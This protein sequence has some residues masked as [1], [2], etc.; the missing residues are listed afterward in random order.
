[1]HIKDIT[2]NTRII[3]A[4]TIKDLQKGIKD[5]IEE[6]WKVMETFSVGYITVEM[7]QGVEANATLYSQFLVKP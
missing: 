5:S 2:E 1:M 4:L 7:Y 3:E 6:G